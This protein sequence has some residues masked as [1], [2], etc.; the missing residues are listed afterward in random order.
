MLSRTGAVQ[1]FSHGSVHV[2]RD[3]ETEGATDTVRQ[4]PQ[5]HQQQPFSQE[6]VLSS[7]SKAGP[8][9]ARVYHRQT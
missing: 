3:N 1:G 5:S 7:T 6:A 9:C 8:P 2:V 4:S